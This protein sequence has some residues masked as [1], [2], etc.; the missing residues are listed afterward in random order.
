WRSTPDS[1]VENSGTVQ[2]LPT[3]GG[4]GTIIK[5]DLEYRPPM[6]ALGATFAKMMGESPEHQVMSDLRRLKQLLETGEIP[7]T[8]GQP[9]GRKTS[10]SP[11]F[12][13]WARSLAEV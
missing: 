10:T 3:T 7:T 6:G 1:T 8:E 9:A 12:D 13:K 4:R 11:K 5:V 2:F